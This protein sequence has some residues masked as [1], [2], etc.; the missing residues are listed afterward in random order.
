MK[1]AVIEE[2][3]MYIYQNHR[4]GCQFYLGWCGL[5]QEAIKNS[6]E[7]EAIHWTSSWIGRGIFALD[8]INGSNSSVGLG[9]Q[10]RAVS[11]WGNKEVLGYNCAWE[12][13]ARAQ[14]GLRWIAGVWGSTV[15][16]GH[17]AQQRA[18]CSSPA[19]VRLSRIISS[20]CLLTLDVLFSL[21]KLIHP[22][23]TTR[24]L[25]WAGQYFI[26]QDI[27]MN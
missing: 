20:T 6:F 24:A 27:A 9:R 16:P 22:Q 3:N 2:K 10:M 23:F 12:G 1:S 21:G 26:V 14:E 4:V 11:V 13:V 19:V 25:L 18:F 7:D 8:S 5:E 17:S 15:L